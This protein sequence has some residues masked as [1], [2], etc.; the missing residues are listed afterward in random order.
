MP[1]RPS[2]TFRPRY[3]PLR[4]ETQTVRSCIEIT[5]LLAAVYAD[6]PPLRQ[7]ICLEDSLILHRNRHELRA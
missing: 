7:L 4:Q 2:A 1:L 6:R 3:A 5:E